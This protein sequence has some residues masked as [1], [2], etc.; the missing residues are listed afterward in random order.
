MLETF[1]L[2][3]NQSSAPV[4]SE[5]ILLNEV[6]AAQRLC[7]SV[8]LLR[9]HRQKRMGCPTVHIGR[10]VRYRLQD[11]EAWAESLPRSGARVNATHETERVQ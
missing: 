5:P 11:V 3:A 10:L 8:A 7:V 4:N 2:T 1:S 9:K 6:E